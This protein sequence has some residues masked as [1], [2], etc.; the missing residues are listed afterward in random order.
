MK[1]IHLFRF[2]DSI[3]H[4]IP[5]FKEDHK[6]NSDIQGFDLLNI[7]IVTEYIINTYDDFIFENTSQPD[8]LLLCSNAQKIIEHYFVIT[9]DDYGFV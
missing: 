5:F 1:A 3:F 2:K 7:E 4:K 8:L 6:L 9:L